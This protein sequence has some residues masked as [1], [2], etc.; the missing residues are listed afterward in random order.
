MNNIKYKTWLWIGKNLGVLKQHDNQIVK[1]VLS[2]HSKLERAFKK[3]GLE[4]KEMDD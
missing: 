4:N 1:S 2:A 3:V